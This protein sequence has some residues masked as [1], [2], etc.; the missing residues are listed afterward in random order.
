MGFIDQKRVNASLALQRGHYTFPRAAKLREAFENCLHDYYVK[1]KIGGHFEA[2]GLLVTGE[3]RVGKTSETVRLVEEF[4][5]SMTAMPNGKLGKIIY[6]KLDGSISWKDL[7]HKTLEALGYPAN[8]RRTQGEL[9]NMV[10]HQ[11]REQDVIGLYYDE[12][13]HAFTSGPKSNEKLLDRFKAL[14][15]EPEWPLMLI[16]SGVPVLASHVNSEEQ[17]AHLLSHIHFDKINLGRFADPTKDPDMIELNKLVYTY[18]ERADIDVEDLVDVD[19][20]Q[21]LDFACASRWGLVIELLIRA[22]GLCRLRSQ[23]TVTVK[24]FSEA[25]AQNSRLPQGLCPFTAPDYRNMID[26]EKLTQMMLDE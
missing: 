16:L 2:R 1:A 17:I 21:R 20:L 19:F 6:C 3:S 5:A 9:W 13:Q 4:N 14:M 15:K 11:C 8:P 22:F 10:R 12:C 18:A 26:G 24:M 23:R 7:G 25:Y